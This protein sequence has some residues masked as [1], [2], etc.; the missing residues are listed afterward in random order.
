MVRR[1]LVGLL[2]MGLLL[3][4]ALAFAQPPVTQTIHQRNQ[5]LTFVAPPPTCEGVGPLYTTTVTRD[6][7]EH[8]TTF[9]D[10][11]VHGTFMERGTFIS[12]PLENPSLPLIP[13][14]SRRPTSSTRTARS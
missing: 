8:T 2:A 5:Q 9:A 11:R 13:A 7:V 3:T 6:F 10:G 14:G 12:V 1:L 4:A